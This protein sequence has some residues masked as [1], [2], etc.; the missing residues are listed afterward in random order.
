MRLLPETDD[1]PIRPD[2]PWLRNLSWVKLHAL[3]LGFFAGVVVYWGSTLGEQGA[4]F[5]LVLYLSRYAL[6]SANV[7]KG[8]GC[9]HNL[10][11]HDIREKPWYFGTALFWT[12]VVSVLAFGAP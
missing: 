8:K 7:R 12:V 2:L 11:A 4:V 10:G 1:R 6:G 9:D 3:Q 5:G